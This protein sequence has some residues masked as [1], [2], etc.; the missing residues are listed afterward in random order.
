[1]F[2]AAN[3]SLSADCGVRC[4]KSYGLPLRALSGVFTRSALAMREAEA[5]TGVRCLDIEQMMLGG[6]AEV[7]GIERREPIV[8]LSRQ[9]SA[10]VILTETEEEISTNGHGNGIAQ[11]LPAVAMAQ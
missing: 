1:V 9:A 11:E 10:P 6:A 7:M 8:R 3:D 4:V 2:F 5:A